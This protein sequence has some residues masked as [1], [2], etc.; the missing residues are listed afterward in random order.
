MSK[1]RRFTNN[2]KTLHLDMD[3]VEAV[4][5]H[6]RGGCVIVTGS[7]TYR[8]DEGHEYVFNVWQRAIRMPRKKGRSE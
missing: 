4:Q 6:E 3:R 7:D 5:E 8:V 2:R 1:I